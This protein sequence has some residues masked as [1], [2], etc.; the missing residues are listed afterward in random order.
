VT[1]S[2]ELSRSGLLQLNKAEAKVEETYE[3]IPPTPPA[4][5]KI[6]VT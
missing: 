5:K 2:F 4:K 1:L 6:N 3:Y